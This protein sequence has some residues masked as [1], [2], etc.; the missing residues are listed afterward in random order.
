VL[1]SIIAPEQSSNESP[2]TL[3]QDPIRRID[4]D[5]LQRTAGPYPWVEPPRLPAFGASRAPTFR[6][7][8]TDAR[9]ESSETNRSAE[10]WLRLIFMRSGAGLPPWRTR[11]SRIPLHDAMPARS[12]ETAAELPG[13]IDRIERPNLSTVDDALFAEINPADQR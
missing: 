2:D 7:T 4:K 13:L 9:P 12:L 5:L 3:M 1:R 6:Q 8:S 10:P 11:S